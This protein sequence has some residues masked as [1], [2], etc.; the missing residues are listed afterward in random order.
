MSHG[1]ATG[2]TIKTLAWYCL[3]SRFDSWV[4]PEPNSWYLC[5]A[6]LSIGRDVTHLGPGS[7][8]PC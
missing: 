4:L 2:V 5:H 7:E 8:S 6:Q 3:I 1:T